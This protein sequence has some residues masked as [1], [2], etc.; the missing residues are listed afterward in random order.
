MIV[1]R[2]ITDNEHKAELKT[3]LLAHYKEIFGPEWADKLPVKALRER[4]SSAHDATKRDMSE[5][6]DKPLYGTV[7]FGIIN[8]PDATILGFALLDIINST[9]KSGDSIKYGQL[10]Q[11]FIKPEYRKEFLEGAKSPEFMAR[12]T[13]ELNNYFKS[14]GVSEVLT[15]I[16]D[17][18]DYL[19]QCGKALGFE[20]SNRTKL[21]SGISQTVWNKQI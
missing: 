2:N 17:E 18:I 9:M 8:E 16:P 14:H 21:D 4:F 7:A 13:E 1:L 19:I 12:L 10:Y 5:L 3:M 11:L 20:Q 15:Q 6:F